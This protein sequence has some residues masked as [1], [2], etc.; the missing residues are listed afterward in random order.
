MSQSQHLAA[1]RAGSND[2]F[3]PDNDSA[4]IKSAKRVLQIL[5]LLKEVRRPLSTTD[6]AI[7]LNYPISSTAALLKSLARLGY[8]HFDKTARTYQASLR[9]GLLGGWTYSGGFAPDVL[10]DVTERLAAETRQTV[11]LGFRNENHIQYVRVVAHET[12]VRYYLPIGSRQRLVD[13]SMGRALLSLDEDGAIDRLVRRANADRTEGQARID[14]AELKAEIH[15]IR[16]RGHA[17]SSDGFFK[18]AGIIAVPLPEPRK[19]PPLVLGLG[20]PAEEIRRDLPRLLEL[21]LAAAAEM[22]AKGESATRG[23]VIAEPLFA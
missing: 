22:S 13:T 12:R 19:E 16:R 5:E 21:T 9:V 15:D 14:P 17:Y 10:N 23:D 18:G 20:G 2:R 11:V 8:L 3:E 4:T 7:Q 1:M 6:I